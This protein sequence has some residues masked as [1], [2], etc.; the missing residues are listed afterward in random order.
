MFLPKLHTK[1]RKAAQKKCNKWWNRKREKMLDIHIKEK[2]RKKISFRDIRTQTSD[3]FAKQYKANTINRMG[4]NTNS[5][6]VHNKTEHAWE[7]FTRKKKEIIQRIMNA[8]MITSYIYLCWDR[9]VYLLCEDW[10]RLSNIIDI[11][12][13]EY[14]DELTFEFHL[15][16]FLLPRW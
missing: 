8:F 3:G 14:K 4:R 10:R 16:F 6:F 11:Y 9:Y 2:W 7:I 13:L 12:S 15:I 5:S 1:S